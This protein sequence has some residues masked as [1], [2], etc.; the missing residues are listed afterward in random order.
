MQ[1]ARSSMLK[2]AAFGAFVG[3][4]ILFLSDLLLGSVLSVSFEWTI[5]LWVAFMLMIPAVI[6]LTYLLASNGSRLAIWGG[7]SAFFGLVAGAS[8]QVL[9]RVYSV[10]QEQGSTATI[11]QLRSTFKLVASTQ[12]IG[13]TW[14]IGLILL[15]IAC[16]T[17]R[18]LHIAVPILFIIG[19][20]AFPIGRIAFS[21]AGV[22]ISGAAF[23]VAFAIIG[24]RL[25]SMSKEMD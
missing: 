17:T 24:M 21:T 12:M 22:L 15:A 3:P 13:L 2:V 8:M 11:E 23:I 4:V 9:F 5:G 18:V 25:W 14:P 6:G 1:R 20:I 7:C 16:L 10:L 19:A